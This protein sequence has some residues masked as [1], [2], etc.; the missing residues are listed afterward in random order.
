M[1]D[2]RAATD[3]GPRLR[4]KPTM[5]AE[6]EP[7]YSAR[8]PREVAEAIEELVGGARTL[9]VDCYQGVHLQE[10]ERLLREALPSWRILRATEAFKAPE[11]IR[12]MVSPDVT[13]DPVFGYVTRLHLHDFFDSHRHADLRGAGS[14]T[15]RP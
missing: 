3:H 13:D 15:A 12:E 6:Q 11:E 14:G 1:A 9:A 4:I 8:G 10:I 5:R 7:R 2:N